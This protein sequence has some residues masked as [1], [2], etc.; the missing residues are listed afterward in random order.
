M[1]FAVGDNKVIK[2]TS[3]RGEAGIANGLLGKK[4]PHC[5]NYYDVVLIKGYNV[6]AI[7]M[8]KAEMFDKKTKEVVEVLTD[9]NVSQCE[10]KRVK[11]SLREAG[12]IKLSDKKIQKIIDDYVKMYKSL[13]KS[14]VS[15]QDLHS[16]NM[17]YLGDKMVHFDMMG[18]SSYRD[19]SKVRI[20]K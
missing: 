10:L 16:E 6:Y 4:I 7:L 17:G 20:R 15:L 8:D 2:L 18:S 13:T 1:A 19:I 5:V 9:I 12:D 11:R 14:G 3:N